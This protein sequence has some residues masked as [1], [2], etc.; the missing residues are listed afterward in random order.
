MKQHA[1]MIMAAVGALV[2]AG[3]AAAQDAPAAQVMAEAPMPAAGPQWGAFSRDSRMI[4]LVETAGIS[5]DGDTATASIARVRRDSPAGD[6]SHVVD[7]FEIQCDGMQSRMMTSTDIEADGESGNAYP[8][9][10]PWTP[11]RTGTFDEMVKMMACKESV[12]A[13]DLF[14]SIKAFIDAG[15]P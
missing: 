14:P 13:G 11:I 12:P 5:Q 4:Y 9:D 6:Y 7:V 8:A 15:R 3:G 2:M 10:E 1:A